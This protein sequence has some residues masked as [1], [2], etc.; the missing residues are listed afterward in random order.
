MTT[1]FKPTWVQALLA[2]VLTWHASLGMAAPRFTVNPTTSDNSATNATVTDAE[3]GLH[4]DLCAYGASN[5]NGTCDTT[6]H[7]SYAWDQALAEMKSGNDNRYLG[8]SDWRLPNIKELESLVTLLVITT[9]DANAFP[10]TPTTTFWTST[11]WLTQ[12][13]MNNGLGL[14][15]E[16]VTAAFLRKSCFKPLPESIS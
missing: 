2:M 10:D 12:T 16:P 7:G 14:W 4:W 13:A 1:N 11:K 15:P 8:Y 3:T 6:S 9:I 5:R